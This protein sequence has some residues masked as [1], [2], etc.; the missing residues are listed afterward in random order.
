M[1]NIKI[2]FGEITIRPYAWK[3]VKR[4][5]PKIGSILTDLLYTI[6]VEQGSMKFHDV[7]YPISTLEYQRMLGGMRNF[8]RSVRGD[9]Q[10]IFFPHNQ[11]LFF[12]EAKGYL[13]ELSHADFYEDGEGEIGFRFFGNMQQGGRSQFFG[14][15]YEVD[16]ADFI[17]FID[18]LEKEYREL[19]NP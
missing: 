16:A 18:E 2:P 12:N 17:G 9:G 4:E 11:V 1:A 15:H 5:K 19:S 3:E 14:G 13:F 6:N 10:E 8:I 7:A